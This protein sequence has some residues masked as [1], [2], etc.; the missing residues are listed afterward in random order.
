MDYTEYYHESGLLPDR[1]YNQLNGKSAAEN[2]KKI[3]LNRQ[4][5]KESFILSIIQ[6]SLRMVVK[7]SLDEIFKGFKM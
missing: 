4:K 2:Y 3:Q 1:Y 6:S 5:K 7:K